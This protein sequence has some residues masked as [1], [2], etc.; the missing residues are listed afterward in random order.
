VAN[1]QNLSPNGAVGFIVRSG[2]LISAVVAKAVR[3]QSSSKL[4]QTPDD[5]DV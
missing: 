4:R 5:I 1:T 3:F 2:S